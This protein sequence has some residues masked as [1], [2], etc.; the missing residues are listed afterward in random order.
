[1][2]GGASAHLLPHGVDERKAPWAGSWRR[3]CAEC[4]PHTLCNS[5]A[6]TTPGGRSRASTDRPGRGRRAP[7]GDPAHAR[8]PR[9]AAGGRDHGRLDRGGPRGLRNRARRSPQ[10]RPQ[11]HENQAPAGKG[12]DGEARSGRAH[13]AARSPLLLCNRGGM[14]AARGIRGPPPVRRGRPARRP[15]VPGPRGGRPRGSRRAAR[16]AHRRRRGRGHGGNPARAEGGR[17][18]HPARGRPGRAPRPGSAA[19][20]AKRA[21]AG[22]SSRRSSAGSTRT[23]R[24]AACAGG[25]STASD[26]AERPDPN[27]QPAADHGGDRPLKGPP[28]GAQAGP[29]AEA[30]IQRPKATQDPHD[31]RQPPCRRSR[32]RRTCSGARA[33]RDPSH[34]PRLPRCRPVPGTFNART[35]R[36]PPPATGRALG[37][38]AREPITHRCPEPRTAASSTSTRSASSRLL[39]RSL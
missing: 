38:L 28:E 30:G 18:A 13:R 33:A 16:Q 6:L 29:P 8:R 17:R 12:P 36:E 15:A 37:S 39:L 32:T 5:C 31:V 21:W 23:T 10:H 25:R 7:L 22:P 24:S 2:R 20:T 34:P 19:K 1:M 11:S 26:G 4:V 35:G 3:L 14:L 9:H 27:R